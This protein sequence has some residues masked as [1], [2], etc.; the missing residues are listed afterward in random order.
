[1][2]ACGSLAGR[3]SLVLDILG[4]CEFGSGNGRGSAGSCP[5]TS[6]W[7]AM[8]IW[9]ACSSYS[10]SLCYVHP[11]RCC[12]L[13]AVLTSR[14]PLVITLCPGL[15]PGWINSVSTSSHKGQPLQ[16]LA[17][18]LHQDLSVLWL[19][20]ASALALCISPLP[21]GSV[22]CASSACSQLHQAAIPLLQVWILLVLLPGTIC[23]S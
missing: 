15:D 18:L 21:A 1:M 23:S 13:I 2:A 4:Q 19:F 14:C 9:R 7:E 11:W 3:R 10:S 20:P 12:C 8:L 22:A 5:A 16:P 17:G 6:H